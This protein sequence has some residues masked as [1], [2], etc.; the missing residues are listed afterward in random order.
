MSNEVVKKHYK[1]K[2]P[3][4]GEDFGEEKEKKIGMSEQASLL[5]P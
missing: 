1:K 2:D 4:T 3:K 5:T